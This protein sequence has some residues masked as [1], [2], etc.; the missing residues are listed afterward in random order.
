LGVFT[1]GLFPAIL[2]FRSIVENAIWRGPFL[3]PAIYR[4]DRPYEYYSMLSLLG[5]LSLLFFGGAIWL[6]VAA[7]RIRRQAGR[8]ARS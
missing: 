4:A 2:L 7:W 6:A 5:F 3:S 8:E 1:F